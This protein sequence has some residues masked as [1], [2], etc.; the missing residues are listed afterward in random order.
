MDLLATMLFGTVVID[1]IKVRG[2]SEGSV[3]TRTCIMAGIIA[4]VLLAAI[5]FSLTYTGATSVAVFGVSDN[6]AIAL[7]SIANY[8]QLL[9]G[10]CRQCG[11][12]PDDFLCLPYNEH[13]PYGIGRFLSGTGAEIQNA[14]SAHSC[15][16]LHLQLCCIQRWL[17]QN[18]FPVGTGVMPA[19]SYCYCAGNDGIHAG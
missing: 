7:S 19:L 6:G 13:W 4:A 9:H 18:N 17:N 16:Y 15:H 12:M 10:H 14:V 5:Y 1:S 2:I 8:Y 11:F 3:L